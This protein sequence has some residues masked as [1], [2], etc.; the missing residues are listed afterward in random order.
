MTVILWRMTCR[1]TN[2]VSSIES[3]DYAAVKLEDDALIKDV[4]FADD[5]TLLIARKSECKF[6]LFYLTIS[7]LKL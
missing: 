3:V 7:N 5:E 4:Q 1:I 6:L 2:G